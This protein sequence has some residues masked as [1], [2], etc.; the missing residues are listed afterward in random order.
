M[1]GA[2]A[3]ASVVEIAAAGAVCG[4]L[5]IG[6][7]WNGWLDLFAQFAPA[8]L[9][10][11]LIGLVLAWPVIAPGGE[12]AFV[13]AVSAVGV[14][15]NMA[16]IGPEMVAA[17][18][19]GGSPRPVTAPLKLLTFN[20]WDEN[21][22][23]DS[24]VD[25]ILAARADIVALQEISILS[26]AQRQRL[27]ATY[28]YWSTCEPTPCELA[29]LS[30]APWT[31]SEFRLLRVGGGLFV[32]WGETLAPDGGPLQLATTH[33]SWPIPPGPQ[34]AERAGLVALIKPM[35][36]TSLIL[37]GDFNLTPWSSALQAQDEA[38]AP[39]IRRTRAVFTWP[40]TIAASKTPSPF[41]LLPIDHI[42]AGPAWRTLTIKRQPR[43]G[44]D[45]YGVLATFARAGP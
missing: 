5:A 43:A 10:L 39:L 4:L 42:Y 25:A 6:G 3:V 26:I 32:V 13:L 37:T 27:R 2:I 14:L 20:V 31:K 11:S 44:S 15:A 7:R 28:P 17:L 36:P 40:A 24:A 8:W 41:P 18:P 38:L 35:P 16:L 9:A 29:L 1:I 23:P 34:A 30:K 33:L 12:R 22:D 19:R 45:H 21:V